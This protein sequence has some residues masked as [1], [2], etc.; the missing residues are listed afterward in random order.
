M[1]LITAP[2]SAAVTP[3][4]DAV[5]GLLSGLKIAKACREHVVHQLISRIYLPIS[6]PNHLPFQLALA[7]AEEH[8]LP[9]L[10][11]AVYLMLMGNTPLVKFDGGVSV[12]RPI[13]GLS[14]LQ[15]VRLTLGL[16]V[17]QTQWVSLQALS[18]NTTVCSTMCST[19]WLSVWSRVDMLFSA[20]GP[21]NVTRRIQCLI[22]ELEKVGDGSLKAV[23][24]PQCWEMAVKRTKDALKDIL[25]GVHFVRV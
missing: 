6:D 11:G 15:Q 25:R 1:S 19:K 23:M 9:T 20:A 12:F 21:E 8:N 5:S 3:S 24:T 22:I 13:H 7:I 16:S 4:R 14:E 17:I 2:T 18:H 10:L